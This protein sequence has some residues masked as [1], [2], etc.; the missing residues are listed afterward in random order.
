M[1]DSNTE[2][3]ASLA[4]TMLVDRHRLRQQWRSIKDAQRRKPGNE[5]DTAKQKESLQQRSTRFQHDLNRSCERADQ[6]RRTVPKLSFDETLPVVVRKDE[7]AA[8]IRDHQVVVICGE[9]GSG[10]S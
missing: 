2:I 5:A 10:K 9:T 3:E 7:I 1:N 4:R 6:R 8:T